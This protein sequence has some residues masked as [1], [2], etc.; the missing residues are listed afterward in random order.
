MADADPIDEFDP[1]PAAAPARAAGWSTHDTSPG[2]LAAIALGGLLGTLARYGLELAW[3]APVGGFPAA[4]FSVNTSGAFL[5]GL[6]LTMILDRLGPTHFLRPFATIGLLG[7]WTTYSSL[8]VESAAL[9]RGGHVATALGYLAA[10]VAAGLVAVAAGMALGR[11][12]A[13]R[14]PIPIDPDWPEEPGEAP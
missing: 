7:G 3:P 8:A 14:V 9:A 10:T 1:A 4:T 2:V 11:L 5:L 6:I 13:P 12:G